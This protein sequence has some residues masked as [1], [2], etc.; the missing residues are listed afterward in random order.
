[1]SNLII[2]Y[3]TISNSDYSWI[4]SIREKSDPRYFEVA[5]PHVTLVFGTEKLT[6]KELITY[7]KGKLAN[8][9]KVELKLDSAIVVEDDTKTFFHAFLVPSTG[10]D[11]VVSI[12]DLLYTDDLASELREDIPFIPHIGIGTSDNKDEMVALVNEINDIKKVIVGSLEKV[13]IVQYDGVKVSD[14]E[15]IPLG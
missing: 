13:T 4:Q 15:N 10:Y 5:K 1:M 9:R 2:A 11:E 12:H 8:L 7:T 6:T 3:P 14:I